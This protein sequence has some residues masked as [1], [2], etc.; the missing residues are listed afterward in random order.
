MMDYTPAEKRQYI[1]AFFKNLNWG[2]IEKRFE[3][4]K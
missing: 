3:N 1:E 2:G 4:A